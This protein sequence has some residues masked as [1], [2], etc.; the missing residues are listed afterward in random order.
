MRR[1]YSR[2]RLHALGYSSVAPVFKFLLFLSP[3]RSPAYSPTSP[4]YSPTR[5]AASAASEL[6]VFKLWTPTSHRRRRS[7]YQVACCSLPFRSRSPAYSPTSPAYSCVALR[8]FALLASYALTAGAA[9][10]IPG[11]PRHPTA[12]RRRRTGTSLRA[13]CAAWRPSLRAPLSL[14]QPQLAH[15][16]SERRRRRRA[17]PAAACMSGRT[18]ALRY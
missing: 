12:P 3:L 17:A 8:A 7:P 9:L 4:A 16:L 6:R 5:Y 18:T 2:L 10:P 11:R 13:T 1:A 15:V 14:L